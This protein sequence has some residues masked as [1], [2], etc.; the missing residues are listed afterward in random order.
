MWLKISLVVLAW[1]IVAVVSEPSKS[2]AGPI[3]FNSALPVAKGEFILRGQAVL[4]RSSDD[5]S[6][7][8]RDLRVLAVPWVLAYGVR[9]DL[10]LFG[11]VPYLDKTMDSTLSSGRV[12]SM[13]ER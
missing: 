4:T 8:D 11:I 10:T 9:R 13:V 3:T 2:D 5:P 1:A 6:T 7:M 12:E